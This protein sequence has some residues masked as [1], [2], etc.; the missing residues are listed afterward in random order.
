M[1][2][3]LSACLVVATMLV[4]GAA[5]ARDAK[6]AV[7]GEKLDN[8]LGSLPDF[9]QWKD[10]PGLA[11]LVAQRVRMNGAANRVAGEKIDSGLGNM[12]HYEQWKHHPVLAPLA[13]RSAPPE[14]VPERLAAGASR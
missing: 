14:T 8:G 9:R 11:L 5:H 1:L 7:E 13:N 10:H 2:R 4:A 6:S 3:K 12:P